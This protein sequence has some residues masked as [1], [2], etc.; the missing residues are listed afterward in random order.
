MEVVEA[1]VEVGEALKDEMRGERVGRAGKVGI[2]PDVLVD[3]REVELIESATLLDTDK[4]CAAT[5]VGV[6]ARA[7]ISFVWR[8][9]GVVLLDSISED[10]SWEEG[11]TVQR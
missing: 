1:T 9:P 4:N 10:V 2:F 7:V 8:P 5:V 3:G 11:E 6:L